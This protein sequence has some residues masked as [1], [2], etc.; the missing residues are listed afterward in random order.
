MSIETRASEITAL[1]DRL[2]ELI[3]DERPDDAPPQPVRPLPEHVPTTAEEA[4]EQLGI[5]R[6]P[7]GRAV[8]VGTYRTRRLR[9]PIPPVLL[10]AVVEQQRRQA[11][12]TAAQLAVGEPP[13]NCSTTRDQAD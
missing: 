3:P 10:L 12:Y 5:S 9:R 8:P 6:T 1:L 2:A 7:R 11:E 4:A 13:G